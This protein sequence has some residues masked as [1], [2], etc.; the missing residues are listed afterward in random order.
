[1]RIS[2]WSSDVCSSD[3]PG[4]GVLGAAAFDRA[5]AEL[6]TDRHEFGHHQRPPQPVGGIDDQRVPADVACIGRAEKG[7]CPAELAYPAHP[8]SRNRIVAA[9][10]FAVARHL[11]GQVLV[12]VAARGDG[13]AAGR[14]TGGWVS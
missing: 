1:M 9:L 11:P 4:N 8:P 3:L 7:R 13:E 5:L 2:D 10:A 6:F 12:R 14:E